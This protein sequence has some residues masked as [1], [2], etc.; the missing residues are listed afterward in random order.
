LALVGGYDQR[1]GDFDRATQAKRQPGSSFKPF[2]YSL[3]LN[4]HLATPATLIAD[5][6][7]VLDQWRPQNF[8]EWRYEGHVRLREALA[9]SI[10]MVAVKLIR[11]LGPEEVVTYAKRLGIESPLD[12]TPTLALGASAVAPIEMAEAYAVFASGGIHA[13]PTLIDEI[14]SPEGRVIH[15]HRPEPARVIEPAQAYLIGSML[16]TVVQRGTGRDAHVLGDDVAGK[17]GTSNDARDAWFVGYAG[18]IACAVWVGFDSPRSLGRRESGSRSALPVWVRFMEHA[19]E[20]RDRRI[21]RP[22]G[23]EVARIDPETGLLAYEGQENA[24]EEEFLDGT[25]P[26]EQAIPPE[27]ADPNTFLME[28]TGGEEPP[29]EPP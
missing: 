4:S 5:A 24:I 25:V 8:E 3:A 19:L 9:K 12:P 18:R 22:E 20:G 7:E 15:P 29:P 28:Q 17:T 14:R 10:N 1:P 6:P 21:D 16:R 23:I 27:M 13:E 26:T 2:V 11:D